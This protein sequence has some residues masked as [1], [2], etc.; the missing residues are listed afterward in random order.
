MIDEGCSGLAWQTDRRTGHGDGKQFGLTLRRLSSH[1]RVVNRE[2][3]SL[4]HV[5]V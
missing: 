1:G 5:A 3:K 2:T 4:Y